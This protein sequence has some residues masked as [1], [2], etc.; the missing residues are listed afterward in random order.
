MLPEIFKRFPRLNVLVANAG[1]SS[2]EN[3]VHGWDITTAEAMVETN[4]LGTLRLVG[5]L[6]PNLNQQADAVIMATTSNLGFVPK[7]MFP[8]SGRLA[9]E[10]SSTRP[11]S[12]ELTV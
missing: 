8:L 11:H 10:Q 3:L 2:A 4:I 6:L 1:S 7:A 9:S 5:A 12:P